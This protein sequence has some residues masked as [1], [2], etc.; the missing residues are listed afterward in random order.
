[1]TAFLEHV[2]ARGATRFESQE[3]AEREWQA[4]VVE[5]QERMLMRRSRGWFTGY[6]ANVAGHGEGTVRYIA[7]WGGAPRY[8]ERIGK[9]AEAQYPGVD[10]A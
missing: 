5:S 10:L 4:E 3:D 2:R 9:L 7:Y 8:N 6:N 1:M